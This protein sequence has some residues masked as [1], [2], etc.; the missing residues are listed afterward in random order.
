MMAMDSANN[1]LHLPIDYG[2]STNMNYTDAP[3]GRGLVWLA[4]GMPGGA[5]APVDGTKVFDAFNGKTQGTIEVVASVQAVTGPGSR[6]ITIGLG[7]E[8]GRFTLFSN[9][10]DR[11]QF[12]WRN[13]VVAGD[14]PLS[15][16]SSGRCVIHVVLD[17]TQLEPTSR[18]LL[19]VNGTIVNDNIGLPPI[20]DS[21]IDIGPGRSLYLGNRDELMRSIGGSLYYAA[22]YS[23]PLTEKEITNHA[24][25]L[26]IND[27]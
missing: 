3:T 24:S 21:T 20:Q 11:V 25:H 16:A 13:N 15:F 1:P 4:P 8:S 10:I 9:T 18:V 26:I 2:G 6:L 7:D 22:L 23:R 14:W 12:R 5:Y 27:D 17:S 19:Y